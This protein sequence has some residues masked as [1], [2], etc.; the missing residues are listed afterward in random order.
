MSHLLKKHNSHLCLPGER[1]NTRSTKRNNTDNVLK[2]RLASDEKV[3]IEREIIRLRV[4]EQLAKLERPFRNSVV[5]IVGAF[6][7]IFIA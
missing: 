2:D 4:K 5:R 1:K 6:R 7:L 3:D